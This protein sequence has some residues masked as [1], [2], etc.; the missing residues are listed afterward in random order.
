[1]ANILISL[2]SDSPNAQ[3]NAT[4]EGTS[5]KRRKS[6][7]DN[8]GDAISSKGGPANRSPR[9]G[10]GAESDSGGS[11]FSES[12][13][14]QPITVQ[15]IRRR[16]S[17]STQ[18]EEKL[19]AE[20]GGGGGA[21][22]LQAQGIQI[23][24]NAG[25]EDVERLRRERNKLHARKTR[26]RKKKLVHEMERIISALE[27]E[28]ESLRSRS[29]SNTI[30]GDDGGGNYSHH[31]SHS[32]SVG[33]GVSDMSAG[34]ISA[35]EMG[36]NV[37]A[38]SFDR[39]VVKRDEANASNAATNNDDG[40]GSNNSSN[41][42]S[43]E[44]SGV[45]MTTMEVDDSSDSK[46]ST[47]S[48]HGTG[49]REQR[50]FKQHKVPSRKRGVA[51]GPAVKEEEATQEGN[52]KEL[53]AQMSSVPKRRR[54]LVSAH[55]GRDQ[56]GDSASTTTTAKTTSEDG[57]ERVTNSGSGSGHSN[58]NSLHASGSDSRGSGG[59]SSSGQAGD[60]AE[61]GSGLSGSDEKD[62]GSDPDDRS[63]PYEGRATV[64]TSE[65]AKQAAQ[66]R[67]ESGNKRRSGG[68]S[69]P[70]TTTVHSAA[71]A[72]ELSAENL[73]QHCHRLAADRNAL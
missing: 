55:K 6:K 28:V 36:A 37:L 33:V 11:L 32:H 58:A 69:K 49:S 48:G 65:R 35:G 3:A 57:T 68:A 13:S 52:E 7:R 8:A 54:L 62:G 1:M 73:E 38:S 43:K 24:S 14:D 12:A 64:P 19:N 23:A 45:T 41:N 2:S 9:S 59:E 66:K 27:E 51:S 34:E 61:D 67:R 22:G 18:R 71:Q 16:I 42:S 53:L 44:S 47:S 60:E 72:S 26:V 4:Q 25:P 63:P 5:S 10:A 50:D 21:T 70:F 20:A 31:H 30:M 29:R 56:T 39:A 15:Q 40:S 17:A 46:L